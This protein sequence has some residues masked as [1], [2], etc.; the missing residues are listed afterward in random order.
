[1]LNAKSVYWI[2]NVVNIWN[3]KVY[4][5]LFFHLF[6]SL[7]NNYTFAPF[8]LANIFTF[9]LLLLLFSLLLVQY[10]FYCLWIWEFRGLEDSW[11]PRKWLF[12]RWFFNCSSDIWCCFSRYWFCLGIHI[13]FIKFRNVLLRTRNLYQ[14]QSQDISSLM[15]FS[16]E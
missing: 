9:I 1:M 12:S 13:V 11:K 2:R 6:F 10:V 7:S 16:L 5:F 14:T 3:A 15:S 4:G 8:D